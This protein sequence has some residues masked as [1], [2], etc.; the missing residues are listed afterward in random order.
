MYLISVTEVRMIHLIYTEK[1]NLLQK[2]QHI[3]FNR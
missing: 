1:C 2:K 3:A